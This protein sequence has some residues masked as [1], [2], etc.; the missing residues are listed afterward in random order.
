MAEARIEQLERDLA[1]AVEQQAAAR[2][3]LEVIGPT[4]TELELVFETVLR[5][6]VRL[7]R[8]DAGLIYVLDEDLPRTRRP[9]RHGRAPARCGGRRARSRCEGRAPLSCNRGGV[10]GQP[11]V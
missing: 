3:V 8:A 1:E 11:Q 10:P 7:C 9:C 6:A 2:A 4:S 5:E